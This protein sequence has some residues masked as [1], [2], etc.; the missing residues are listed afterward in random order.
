MSGGL[1]KLQAGDDIG[2]F[3]YRITKEAIGDYLPSLDNSDPWYL[4]NSPFGEAIVPHGYFCDDF[5]RLLDQIDAI[6]TAGFHAK[7]E[8]ELKGPIRYGML[9]TVRGKVA[10]RYIKR[11]REYL[12]IE[13]VVSD[14]NECELLVGKNTFV[15]SI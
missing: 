8:Y 15:T 3:Q 13:T 11:E 4:D 5:M 10:A 2:S 9:L 6:P 1:D 12:E 7:S 14:E